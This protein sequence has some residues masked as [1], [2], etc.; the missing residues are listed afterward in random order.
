MDQRVLRVTTFAMAKL[1]GD[2]YIG[3]NREKS[4]LIVHKTYFAFWGATILF[5]LTVQYIHQHPYIPQL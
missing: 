5:S 2:D 3:N 1:E 4:N